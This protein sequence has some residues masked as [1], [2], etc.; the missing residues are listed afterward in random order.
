ML[1]DSLESM[2]NDMNQKINDQSEVNK[3][4]LERLIHIEDYVKTIQER[5][6]H[7]EERLIHVEERFQIVDD[8]KIEDMRGR[9]IHIEDKVNIVMNQNTGD[10]YLK[11]RR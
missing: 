11:V 1:Q 2:K 3:E 10:I 8:D 4:I 6:E 7:I 5:C 9:L